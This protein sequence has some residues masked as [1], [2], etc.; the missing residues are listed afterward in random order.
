LLS[1]FWSRQWYRRWEIRDFE[2]L[3]TLAD[4]V[5]QFQISGGPTWIDSVRFDIEGK[6]E[7][8]KADFDQLR[9]MLRSVF[10]DRFSLKLHHETKQSSVYALVPVNGGPKLDL[11]ANQSSPDISAPA[12]K[13]AGPNRGAIRMGAGIIAGNAVTLSLCSQGCC[14]NG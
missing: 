8:P 5:Q 7:D 1:S 10:E 3:I 4:R 12:P 2:K 14:R 11:S 9:L 13:G 6:A